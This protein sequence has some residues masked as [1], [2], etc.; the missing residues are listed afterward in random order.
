VVQPKQIEAVMSNEKSRFDK[1]F[2]DTRRR[3]LMDLREQLRGTRAAEQSEQ[4]GVNANS[5]GEAREY[6]DDGQ[7]LTTLELEGNLEARDTDR[8]VNVERALRKI[9]EGTYGV[10]DASGEPIPM[11]RLE[12]VPDAIYTLAE[13]EALDKKASAR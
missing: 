12:V 4:A 8:L 10:S 2:L 1:S 3:Q 13:Q 11:A 5:A 7:K 9:D 6:G